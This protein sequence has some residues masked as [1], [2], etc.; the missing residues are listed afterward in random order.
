MRIGSQFCLQVSRDPHATTSTDPAFTAVP[1]YSITGK[2]TNPGLAFMSAEQYQI[3]GH[4]AGRLGKPMQ[5][6]W[7]KS[8]VTSMNGFR[9]GTRVIVGKGATAEFMVA[10]DF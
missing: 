9:M 7:S 10:K 2:V 8:H 6:G 4:F 5:A 3:N 1:T